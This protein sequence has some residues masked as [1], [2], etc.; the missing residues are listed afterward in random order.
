MTKAWCFSFILDWGSIGDMGP[1]HRLLWNQGA[2]VARFYLTSHGEQ[3][4]KSFLQVII[5]QDQLPKQPHEEKHFRIE[6]LYKTP[7]YN[8]VFIIKICLGVLTYKVWIAVTS[9][10]L[11]GTKKRNWTTVQGQWDK[12]WKYSSFLLSRIDLGRIKSY[13]IFISLLQ[14]LYLSFQTGKHSWMDLH[15]TLIWDH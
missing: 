13:C 3:R 14:L 7:L 1:S 2:E 8:S 5:A 15:I 6:S 12:V 10:F 9:F 11:M 4:W